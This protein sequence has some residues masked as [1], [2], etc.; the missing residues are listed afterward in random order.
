MKSEKTY[1]SFIE[2]WPF[3]LSQH[4]NKINRWLHVVGALIGISIMY[5]SEVRYI[6]IFFGLIAGYFFAWLGHFVFEKNRPATFEYPLYSFIADFKMIFSILTCQSVHFDNRKKIVLVTGASRG[7]GLSIVKRLLQDGHLVIAA[8]RSVNSEISNLK[9]I[10]SDRLQIEVVDV[11]RLDVVASLSEK[12]FTNLNDEEFVIINNAGISGGAP[13]ELMSHDHWKDLFAVNVFG[14]VDMT[15]AFMPLLRKSKGK[16]INI[17]SISGRVTSPLMTSYSSSK[18]AVR[19]ISDGLRRELKLQNISVVLI[20]PGPT[21]TDIWH[22]S[23]DRSLEL[24]KTIPEELKAIY[25]DQIDSL[26]EDVKNISQ[27]TVSANSVS[28]FVSLSVSLKRPQPYYRVGKNIHLIY[29]ITRLLPTAW[30]D[31]L[32]TKGLRFKKLK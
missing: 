31:K 4:Q 7:I 27:S 6:G 29:H 1:K 14:L 13:F 5:F 21:A 2:F 22:T 16:V 3:Y 9:S 17:G 20:E 10:Y 23:T 25:S 30:L 19:A 24:V 15:R 8:V 26:L 18:F 28:S 12:L 11:T 32:L